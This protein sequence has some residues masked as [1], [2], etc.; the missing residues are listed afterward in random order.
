MSRHCSVCNHGKRNDIDAAIITREPYRDMAARFSLSPS[1]VSRHAHIHLPRTLMQAQE[2]DEVIRGD[3]LLE[4][5][6]SLQDRTMHIL[7][8]AE[9]TGDLREALQAIREIRSNMELLAKLIGELN[10]GVNI[11]TASEWPV[12]RSAI[13]IAL[14]P[15]PE[16]K[17]HLAAA[18][19]E[20]KR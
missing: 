12:L 8:E 14:E 16:A 5:V 11:N 6:P 3:S 15:Y 10:D 17:A 2:A 7:T 9:D 20:V 1:S 18:L 19:G 4:Q 13:L